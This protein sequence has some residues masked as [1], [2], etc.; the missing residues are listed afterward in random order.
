[1]STAFQVFT[2]TEDVGKRLKTSK[3]RIFYRFGFVSDPEKKHEIIMVHSLMSGKKLVFL[4]GQKVHGSQSMT[5]GFHL[6]LEVSGSLVSVGASETEQYY[7][8]IDGVNF[9]DLQYYSPPL[10]SP[11]S[12]MTEDQRQEVERAHAHQVMHDLDQDLELAMRMQEE[13]HEVVRRA[14]VIESEDER[15]AR[16]LQMQFDKEHEEHEEYLRKSGVDV[17][18]LRRPSAA[19]AS[20]TQVSLPPPAPEPE[21]E[22]IDLLS[23]DDED[24]V[25]Q[26]PPIDDSHFSSVE[27]TPHPVPPPPVAVAAGAKTDPRTSTSSFSAFDDDQVDPGPVQKEAALPPPI[28]PTT[29]SRPKPKPAGMKPPTGMKPPPELTP[30][31]TYND[32]RGNLSALD[33]LHPDLV[34]PETSTTTAPAATSTSTTIPTKNSFDALDSFAGMSNPSTTNTGPKDNSTASPTYQT[35]SSTPVSPPDLANHLSTGLSNLS[36]GAAPPL[37]GR[38]MSARNPFDAYDAAIRESNQH[39]AKKEGNKNTDDAFAGLGS[40]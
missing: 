31:V 18:T 34:Q 12:N 13:E 2:E 1:M 16:E 33:D 37:I 21:P 20:F 29:P 14:S 28:K 10:T 38:T 9:R 35:L 7:L 22:P 24:E 17:S 6:D 8:R 40:F 26:P 3:K 39:D 36:V 27:F 19:P 30:T 5:A 4:N 15:M 23:F 25:D 32:A 11:A